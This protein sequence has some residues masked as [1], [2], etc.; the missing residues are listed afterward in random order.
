[1]LVTIIADASWCP[2]TG[3]AGWGAWI[4]TERGKKRV[5]GP[6]KIPV[7]SA[8]ASEMMGIVNAFWEACKA[9]LVQPYDVVLLQTDCLWGLESFQGVRRCETEHETMA[10]EHLHRYLKHYSVNPIYR[11]VKGHTNRKEARYVVN[12]ICD[13]DAKTHMRK[14]RKHLKLKVIR[15][16]IDEHS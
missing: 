12:D 5:G 3:A 9:G 15:D 14:M 1:M 16:S 11:H 7:Q 4:A 6:I 8:K 13:Q 2:H 10:V